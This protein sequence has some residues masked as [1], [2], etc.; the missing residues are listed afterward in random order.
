MAADTAEEQETTGVQ[1]GEDIQESDV[2]DEAFLERLLTGPSVEPVV[3]QV[4]EIESAIV[5]P[6]ESVLEEDGP[7]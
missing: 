6:S 7:C 2:I 1:I 3:E 5:P 4:A